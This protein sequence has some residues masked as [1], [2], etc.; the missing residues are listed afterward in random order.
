MRSQFTP[1]KVGNTVMRSLSQNLLKSSLHCIVL[2]SFQKFVRILKE[3][4][5]GF[6]NS[7]WSLRR[8][9]VLARKIALPMQIVPMTKFVALMSAAAMFAIEP[10][11][12]Q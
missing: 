7:V 11:P 9:R 6:P 1:S 4:R 8:C 3:L 5:V 2:I 10:N 12:D